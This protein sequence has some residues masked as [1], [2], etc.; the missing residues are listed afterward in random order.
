MNLVHEEAPDEEGAGHDG[1]R[2]VLLPG[3]HVDMVDG[4]VV[5]ASKHWKSF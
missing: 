2:V 4:Q 1:S 5:L 3:L